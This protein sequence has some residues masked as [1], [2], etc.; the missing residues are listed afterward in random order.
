MRNPKLACLLLLGLGC[1]SPSCGLVKMP[2][3]VLGAVAQHSYAAGEHAV[4][5]SSQALAKRNAK[6]QAAKKAQAND[7]PQEQ[8]QPTTAP[9]PAPAAVPSAAPSA[10]PSAAPSVAP[11]VAPPP[12]PLPESDEAVSATTPPPGRLTASL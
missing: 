7:K 5:A 3:R 9:A 12:P 10:V 4:T 6:K 11:S 8:A 1:G 2:G